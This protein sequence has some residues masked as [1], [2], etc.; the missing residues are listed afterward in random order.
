MLLRDPLLCKSQC[1]IRDDAIGLLLVSLTPA[2]GMPLR[3][4]QPRRPG[5]ARRRASQTWTGM[6]LEWLVHRLRLPTPSRSEPPASS[7]P[8]QGNHLRISNLC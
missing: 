1:R 8:S 6:S 7:Q 2:L 3:V 5:S 4:A